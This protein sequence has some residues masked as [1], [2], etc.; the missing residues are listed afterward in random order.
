MHVKKTQ[1]SF[2]RPG[3]SPE[4]LLGQMVFNQ[5]Q[6]V[7]KPA[8]SMEDILFLTI[9]DSNVCGDDTNNWVAPLSFKEPCQR[10]PN[11]SEQ[12]VK[13]FEIPAA[14]LQEET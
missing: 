2:N 8:P 10:L 11:N 13:R 1:P 5:T 14:K 6:Y 7:N 4:R 12:V 9:T 3:T